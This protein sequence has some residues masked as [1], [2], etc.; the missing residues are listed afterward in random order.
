MVN[1]LCQYF[2]SWWFLPCDICVWGQG[3]LMVL[4]HSKYCTSLK[5]SDSPMSGKYCHIL[6]KGNL[7]WY[8]IAFQLQGDSGARKSWCRISSLFWSW[9][10]F[11]L[12]LLLSHWLSVLLIA[13]RKIVEVIRFKLLPTHLYTFLIDIVNIHSILINEKKFMYLN[14]V[15]DV[16]AN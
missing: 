4:L 14:A 11:N 3:S 13:S 6:L 15:K 7:H 2:N 1:F 10:R 9:K 5:P 16:L 8:I 12:F